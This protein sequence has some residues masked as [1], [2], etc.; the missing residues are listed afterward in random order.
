M[1]M[2]FPVRLSTLTAALVFTLSM[3]SGCVATSTGDRSAQGADNAA[4]AAAVGDPRRPPADVS[5]DPGR[6]PQELLEFARLRPGQSVLDFFAGGGYLTE[7]AYYVVGSTGKVT[8][9][10]N[11]AYARISSKEA[12]GR[13]GSGRLPGVQQLVSANNQTELPEAAYDVALF[14]MAYHDVYYLDGERGWERIDT[15]RLLGE[16]Y[17]S[18]K[19]GGTVL[20]VDHVARPGIP[21]E[22]VRTLH[23]IDPALIKAD[24][25]AAGF[26]L[27]G[28]ADFLRNP[29]DQID[30]MAML[31]PV[32]GKT[33]RAVL[34][35]V[36]P[37]G[38]K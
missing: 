27:D 20:V 2:M 3:T 9:Y 38:A 18:I 17:R 34:R 36:R 25:A 12:E 11:A 13:Y 23:R 31:P 32:I 37:A 10:N 6:K 22:Q 24:F 33:D 7:L 29:A 4:I 1:Q 14:V 35:F 5:R 21:R 26:V 28:E 19:P 8:V 15:S 16:L 30:V